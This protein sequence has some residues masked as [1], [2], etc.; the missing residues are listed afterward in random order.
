MALLSDALSTHD[1]CRSQFHD[2]EMQDRDTIEKNPRS[3]TAHSNLALDLAAQQRF[4][5]AFDQ[6]NEAHRLAPDNAW[7]AFNYAKVVLD[8]GECDGLQ[9]GDIDDAIRYFQDAAHLSPGWADPYVGLGV[10]YFRGG[11]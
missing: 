9:P 1:S 7:V 5:E 11:N 10:A 2:G 6:L 8:R 3:W 4:D